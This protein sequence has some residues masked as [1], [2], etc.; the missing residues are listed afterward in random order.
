MK[1]QLVI[2]EDDK[3]QRTITMEDKPNGECLITFHP[4]FQ[5]R[6]CK[7]VAEGLC[8]ELQGYVMTA[9]PRLRI[10]YPPKTN[11]G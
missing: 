10:M 1:V 9:L 5:D 8:A 7:T 6:E 2:V 4:D 3:I 11:A